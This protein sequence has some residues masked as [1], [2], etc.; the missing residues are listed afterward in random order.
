MAETTSFPTEWTGHELFDMNDEKVGIIEDVRYG[1]TVGGLTWLVVKAHPLATKWI[2]VPAGEVH[3]SEGRV[4][5][6]LP[7]E[8]LENVPRE[9]EDDLLSP[10][11]EKKILSFYGLKYVPATLESDEGSAEPKVP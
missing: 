6:A 2:F 9:R 7:K 3:H 4:I 11:E 1:D 10:A 8:R 5:V